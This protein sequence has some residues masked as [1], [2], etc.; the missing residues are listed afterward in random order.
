MESIELVEVS[1]ELI[2]ISKEYAEHRSECAKHKLAFD[3][4]L[5][6][7]INEFYKVKKNIGYETS[8]LM[9]MAEGDEDAN[10]HDKKYHYHYAQYK[11]IDKIIDALRD[12]INLEKYFGRV[13]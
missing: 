3:T 6:S 12:K 5:A 10:Y 8:R 9:L 11:G 7:K 13:Q 2:K 1:D 4:I